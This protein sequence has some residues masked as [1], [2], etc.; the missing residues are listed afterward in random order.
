MSVG[1]YF[2]KESARIPAS[3]AGYMELA[4]AVK[5]ADCSKVEV[6][7]GVSRDRGCCNE[8]HPERKSVTAFRCG[9]CRYVGAK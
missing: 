1:K 3:K 4:G 5:D 7:G 8:F 2:G 6:P 9:T